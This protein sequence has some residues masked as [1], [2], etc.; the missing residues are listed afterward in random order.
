MVLPDFTN[1]PALADKFSRLLIK[2]ISAF[3]LAG[4]NNYAIVHLVPAINIA[5]TSLFT[6]VDIVSNRFTVILFRGFKIGEY[7]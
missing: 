3:Q 1:V 5:K 4:L 6:L 7:Q 2:N